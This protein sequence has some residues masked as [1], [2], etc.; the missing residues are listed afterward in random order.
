MRLAIT[1]DTHGYHEDALFDRPVDV[2]VHCGDATM[3]GEHYIIEDMVDW[4]DSLRQG[5]VCREIIF[6]PGNHDFNFDIST[7]R[8]DPRSRELVHAKGVHLLINS[9]VEIDGKKFYGAPAVSHL[10]GWAFYDHNR[11]PFVDAPTDIDVLVT[12]APAFG[13]LDRVL[14]G[15]HVGSD[16]ILKH[17]RRCP[18]VKVHAHGHIHEDRGLRLADD[19]EPV[20]YSTFNASLCDRR[21]IPNGA[22]LDVEI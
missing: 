13:T 12:H 8:F 7:S 5:G 18:K 10:P 22:V 1:S 3:L 15:E 21:Y 14:S 17:L 9:A 11:D 16:Y 4:F 6:V 2:L 19:V 20:P